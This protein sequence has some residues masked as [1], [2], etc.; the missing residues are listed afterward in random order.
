MLE[1]ASVAAAFIRAT[2]SRISREKLRSGSWKKWVMAASRGS[3]TRFTSASFQL[4]T[5]RIEAT[6]R[7]ATSWPESRDAAAWIIPSR[8]LGSLTTRELSE[9]DCSSEK[10]E[11]G[12]SSRCSYASMRTSLTVCWVRAKLQYMPPYSTAAR[13]R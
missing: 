1:T 11:T 7:I 13:K 12:S 4:M 2:V 8:A 10:R 5:T 3:T 9:P 6:T